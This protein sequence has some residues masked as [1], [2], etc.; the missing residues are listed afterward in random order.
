MSTVNDFFKNCSQVWLDMRTIPDLQEPDKQ[1]SSGH[2]RLPF[3]HLSLFRILF[4]FSSLPFHPPPPAPL[5]ARALS[6]LLWK[7]PVEKLGSLGKLRFLSWK[8]QL[9]ATGTVGLDPRGGSRR[10]PGGRPNIF[11]NV[12]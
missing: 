2:E 12:M 1:V 5:N 7:L 6:V 4:H 10:R 11:S 9:C 8:E 3:L